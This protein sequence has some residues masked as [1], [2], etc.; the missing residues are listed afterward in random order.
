MSDPLDYLAVASCGCIKG[1]CSAKMP[2]SDIARFVAD[3]VKSGEDL[4]RVTT[5]ESRTRPWYCAKHKADRTAKQE[6][7]AL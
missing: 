1:W 6:E 3:V 2:R 4:Q 5:E 7:M